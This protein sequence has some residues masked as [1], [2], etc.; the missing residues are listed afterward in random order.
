MSNLSQLL[1]KEMTRRQFLITLGVG[2][3]SLFGLSSL[4]GILSGNQPEIEGPVEY[5]MKNYGP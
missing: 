5:G 1:S 2:F 4:M 3:I